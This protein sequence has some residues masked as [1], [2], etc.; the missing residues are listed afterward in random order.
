MANPHTAESKIV[1]ISVLC[2]A[3]LLFYTGILKGLS[4]QE[5]ADFFL[6]KAEQQFSRAGK[7]SIVVPNLK[8]EAMKSDEE[9][10]VE[11][12]E[13]EEEPTSTE[14]LQPQANAA[15]VPPSTNEPPAVPT[16][17]PTPLAD[18]EPKNDEELPPPKL[19]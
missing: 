2:F 4:N 16:D 13:V 19:D 12:E 14:T 15:L 6:S 7:I 10:K 8:P 5:E 1:L 3:E 18:S 11:E 9:E 17:E